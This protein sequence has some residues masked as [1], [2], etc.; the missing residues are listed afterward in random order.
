MIFKSPYP[1]V[2]IPDVPLADFVLGEAADRGDKPALIDG[3][4][5]RTIGYRELAHAVS[6]VAAG[7]ARRGLRKGDVFA[8]YSP[9][10]RNMRL[11]CTR[12]P[13]WAGS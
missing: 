10:L 7:L 3:P 11:L 2:E 1:D 5:G 8:I 9:N 4:T 12:W 6:R 13:P